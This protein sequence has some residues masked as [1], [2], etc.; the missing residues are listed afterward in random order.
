MWSNF[1]THSHYC[2]GKDTLEAYID[3]AKE[4]HV[5]S[6]GFSSHAPLPFPCSW[7]MKTERYDNYLE[8]ISRLKTKTTDLELYAGLEIDFIPGIISPNSFRNSL[9]YTIGSI[10]FVEAL[11]DG[12]RWE[13]DGPHNFFLEGLEKVFHNDIQAAIKRYYELTREMIMTSTPD[14]LGHLDKIKIQNIDGDFFREDDQWY[15]QEIRSTLDVIERSGVVV[16]VNTRGIYQKKSS[17]TYPS[18]WILELIQ[19]RNIPVTL[20]TDAHHPDD[21]INQF[22]ESAKMLHKIGF[23]ELMTLRKGKWKAY[24]FNEHGLMVNQ[25]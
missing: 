21:L 6:L 16:E 2:D 19:R 15:Q 8:T 18:P 25:S 11:P 9:D 22:P 1:H 3:K 7:C 17:T 20:S 5:G 12:R 4:L 10:H 13:I 23:R 24:P 14:I